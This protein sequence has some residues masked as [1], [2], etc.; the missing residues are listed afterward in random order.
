MV[1]SRAKVLAGLLCVGMGAS[2][3]R[4]EQEAEPVLQALPTTQASTSEDPPAEAAAVDATHGAISGVVTDAV[5]GQPLAGLRVT[6]GRGPNWDVAYS[7]TGTDGVY[8]FDNLEPSPSAYRVCVFGSGYH[9]MAWDRKLLGPETTWC[10]ASGGDFVPVLAGETTAGINLAMI[11]RGR[12]SGRLTDAKTGLPI[13]GGRVWYQHWFDSS[14]TFVVTDAN[15]VY[16]TNRMPMGTARVYAT[17]VGY[18]PEA[19]DNVPIPCGSTACGVAVSVVPGQTT[20]GLDFVLEPGARVAGKVI[21]STTSAPLPNVTV[22]LLDTSG[23]T[24]FTTQTDASGQYTLPSTDPSYISGYNWIPTGTY[25]LKTSGST[26][27]TDELYDNVSCPGTC[28][29]SSGT[30]VSPVEGQTT[31]GID[32]ALTLNGDIKGRVVDAVTG[33]PLQYASIWV[34]TPSGSQVGSASTD[35]DG[36]YAIGQN[37]AD[38]WHGLPTGSYFARA[39]M[40]KYAGQLYSGIPCEPDCIWSSG[41]PIQV[42]AG[43][44]TEGINFAL[45]EKGRIEGRV[46]IAG[47]G[48]PV[49]GVLM[50]A[51]KGSSSSDRVAVNTDADGRYSLRGLADGSYTVWAYG[52]TVQAEVYD[53]VPCPGFPCS[54]IPGTPVNTGLGQVASGI[55]FALVENGRIEGAVIDAAT[56]VPIADAWVLLYDSAGQRIGYY[57]RTGSDGTYWLSAAPSAGTY[58]ARAWAVTHRD[59]MY[60][61]LPCSPTCE[62]TS[63]TPLSLT[64]G[65]TVTGVNFALGPLDSRF[66]SVTP[67]R[68]LDTRITGPSLGNVASEWDAK[69]VALTEVCG[70]PA[71]ARAVAVNVTVTGATGSGH[72]TAFTDRLPIVSTLNF[73][74]GQT[75][76]NSAVLALDALGYIKLRAVL[77]S[78]VVYPFPVAHVIIDVSGYFQ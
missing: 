4:G 29:I 65:S 26:R 7:I 71:S 33:A 17:P 14:P 20:T 35:A 74:A 57:T 69:W 61:D 39:T 48:A 28:T 31:S 16:T 42:V 73:R 18:R 77:V 50:T 3:A 46:T 10:S 11:E 27:H 47:T 53:D 72:L 67:C 6:L 19:Y 63:A 62:V 70:I 22:S 9:S 13:A 5:T 51:E 24:K 2:G 34:Q 23:A 12:L 78:D 52:L 55:D 54:G 43:Q 36:Y 32:F 41:T 58:F 49:Q 8:G 66:H 68:V 15:G 76:G 21:E 38:G 37:W 56:G 45:T 25:Y 1:R 40:S 30:P 60:D 64:P 75:R 59:E 44:V